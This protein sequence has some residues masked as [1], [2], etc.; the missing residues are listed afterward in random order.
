[1]DRRSKEGKRPA[2]VPSAPNIT[3]ADEGWLS[4]GD[5]LGTNE[6]YVAIPR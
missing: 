1:M 2:I 6:G 3:Y 5:W 4:W